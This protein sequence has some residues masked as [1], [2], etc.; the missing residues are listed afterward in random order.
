[1]PVRETLL[2]ALEREAAIVGRVLP[3]GGEHPA[4]AISGM[5]PIRARLAARLQV[6]AGAGALLS[7]G[8]AGA[9]CSCA[10]AGDVVLPRVV[11][12]EAGKRLLV[13]TSMHQR[14]ERA[15]RGGFRIRC[16]ALCST[17]QVLCEATDKRALA[18]K[19]DAEAVD[20]ESAAIGGVARDAGLPFAVLRVICD[21]PSQRIPLCATQSIDARGRILRA[22][23]FTGLALRPW[24]LPALIA[25]GVASMRA[26]N[27]LERA[28]RAVFADARA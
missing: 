26:A 10:R 13:D 15:L 19:W 7:I 3:Q 8:F 11:I 5:G 18:G 22:R 17:A 12:D 21:G 27:T 2:V 1:M 28:M 23:L 14:L 4:L 16:G 20:M 9:L 24:E 6:A 25:L